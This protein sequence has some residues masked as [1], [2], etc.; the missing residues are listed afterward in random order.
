MNT[1]TVTVGWL[2]KKEGAGLG[3]FLNTQTH[4]EHPDHQAARVWQNFQKLHWREHFCCL[5][6]SKYS[7]ICTYNP[8]RTLPEPPAVCFC[9][10]HHS[11]QDHTKVSCLF[12]SPALA[13]PCVLVPGRLRGLFAVQLICVLLFWCLYKNGSCLVRFMSLVEAFVGVM[14]P[15]RVVVSFLPNIVWYLSRINCSIVHY[16][17][18]NWISMLAV[19]D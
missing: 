3:S 17:R 11:Y 9:L 5:L 2:R 8:S 12:C 16:I 19:S 7:N 1:N 6:K 15:W 18:I 10:V 13:D 4:G 14:T